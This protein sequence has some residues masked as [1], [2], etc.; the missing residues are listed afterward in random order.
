MTGCWPPTKYWY[1]CPNNKQKQNP[2][3][4]P[5]LPKGKVPA[6]TLTELMVVL[7]L[8]GLL[9][10]VTYRVLWL[11]QSYMNR[12]SSNSGLVYELQTMQVRLQ[13]D[14]DEAVYLTERF[15]RITCYKPTGTVTYTL[16]SDR[17]LRQQ[18]ARTDT[19]AVAPQR[20]SYERLRLPQGG[21]LLK[22]VQFTTFVGDQELP[23]GAAR[24]YPNDIFYRK[25]PREVLNN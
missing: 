7:V 20:I 19:F 4:N 8:S 13:A 15:N 6:F 18:A 12:F 24:S 22:A 2:S 11:S 23:F 21:A 16:A 17:I 14:F 3:P 25:L 9:V 1:M 5:L 10:V